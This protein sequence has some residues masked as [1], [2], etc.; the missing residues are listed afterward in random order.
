MEAL[1][2]LLVVDEL[3]L[4]VVVTLVPVLGWLA[5]AITPHNTIAPMMIPPTIHPF[6]LFFFGGCIGCCGGICIG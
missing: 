3:V 5:V 1:L 2:L 6:L 4:V